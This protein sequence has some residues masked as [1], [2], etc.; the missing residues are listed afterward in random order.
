MAEG[1]PIEP[2]SQ[3]T[4]EIAALGGDTL[5]LCYQ[6]GTCTGSC[7]SGRITAFRIRKLLRKAQLGMRDDVLTS[8]DLWDCTTC[9]TCH[10]RCPRGV[11]IP[12]IVMIMRNIAV[13]E[14]NMAE[15]HKKV[16]GL[17]AKTGHMVPLTDE[18]RS[19]RERIGLSS[20]PPT[21]LMHEDATEE[22]H[23]IVKSTGFSKLIGG[24]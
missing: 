23:K 19:L 2:N 9:Y 7:P 24:E 17:L 21:V 8:D 1:T 11:Q 16:A 12:D 13:Q 5:N 22:I 14:G 20:T 18:Y 3:F 15:Q 6:C 4:N 10:E